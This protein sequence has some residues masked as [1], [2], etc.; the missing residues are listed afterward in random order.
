MIEKYGIAVG[1]QV[2]F[3][4]KRMI[5]PIDTKE[6]SRLRR[7]SVCEVMGFL[8]RNVDLP[9]CGRDH[10][11]I[12]RWCR[13]GYIIC[14]CECRRVKTPYWD[15]IGLNGEVVYGRLARSTAELFLPKY[16]GC[17]IEASYASREK[18]LPYKPSKSF[19]PKTLFNSKEE[20]REAITRGDLACVS[21]RDMLK[22]MGR[23]PEP[24]PDVPAFTKES[25]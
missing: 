14:P 19:Y 8:K 5:L 6:K 11:M 23:I 16:P 18:L 24:E 25:Q 13:T 15:L 2:F 21:I 9:C 17:T 22:A 12:V 7:N 20:E 3:K 4:S 1:T 10:I